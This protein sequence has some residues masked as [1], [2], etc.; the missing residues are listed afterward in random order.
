[1]ILFIR[2]LT[3]HKMV[4]GVMVAQRKMDGSAMGATE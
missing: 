4:G 2:W 3:I 1:M